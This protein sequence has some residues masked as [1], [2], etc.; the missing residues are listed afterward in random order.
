M[1]GI[2]LVLF[3]LSTLVGA[4]QKFSLELIEKQPL[5]TDR[6]VAMDNFGLFYHIV[7]EV[8]LQL[9][10][11]YN[12]LDYSNIQ[13][14]KITS[15]NA[16]NPLKINLFYKDFNAVVI[17]DN[18]LAEIT[19]VDFNRLEPFRVVTHISTGNDNTIWLYNQNTQQLE[20]F[21]YLSLKTRVKTLPLNEEIVDLKSNYNHCW[22]L[23]KTHLLKY[24]YTGSLIEKLAIEGV[25][26]IQ[27]SD[28]NVFLNTGDQLF[29]NLK[30]STEIRPVSMPQLLINQFLVTNETLYIYNEGILYKYRLKTN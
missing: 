26:S 25:K 28:G 22:V 11:R 2:T 19:K 21:D 15:A 6:L 3:L 27:I 13:F 9:H 17:L 7:N 30:N 20:L 8:E 4:Q 5:E 12:K 24:N 10:G 14:G 29:I 16:F 23:T 1:K 18:R